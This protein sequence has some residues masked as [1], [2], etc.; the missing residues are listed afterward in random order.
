[1]WGIA[2]NINIVTLLI[3]YVPT[4]IVW[5]LT[6][7][8]DDGIIWFFVTW[9]GIMT[10]IN[11]IRF[12]VVNIVKVISFW[13]DN[14]TMVTS[15]IGLEKTYAVSKA[16]EMTY[17]DFATEWLCFMVF[18]GGYMDLHTIIEDIDGKVY[19]APKP[20]VVVYVPQPKIEVYVPP[21]RIEVNVPAPRIEVNVPA[22]RVDVRVEP[23]R[24]EPI[25]IKPVVID[26]PRPRV[27]PV[28]IRFGDDEDRDLQF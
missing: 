18:Y 19:I 26:V 23:I 12:L 11:A 16:H 1:M 25:R 9:T 13:Y 27:D 3:Q 24:V 5:I 21:P 22:P 14:E 6:C 28:D 17:W 4:A 2:Q 10:Y 20:K 8:N 7:S 15:Y